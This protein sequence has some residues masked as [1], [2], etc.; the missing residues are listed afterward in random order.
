VIPASVEILR[1]RCF[2]C[3]RA[4]ASL[5]FEDGAALQVIGTG[6]LAGSPGLYKTV[7]PSCVT[8]KQPET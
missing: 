7:L 6:V 8:T 4:I 3:C 2:A 5:T 1:E